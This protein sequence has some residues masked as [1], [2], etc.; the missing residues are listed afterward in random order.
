MGA[1]GFS[2]FN[3]LYY[4]AAHYTTA[5]NLGI[6][7]GSLPVFVLIGAFLAYR[8]RVTWF[9][10]IGVALT[11]AGVVLVATGGNVL[12]LASLAV[13][14]G[15]FLMVLACVCYGAYA[16]ALRQ[17][18]QASSLGLF[19][20]L[21]GAALITAIPMAATEAAMGRFQWPTAQGWVVVAL[22][23][24]FPSFLAQIFFIKGVEAIGPGRAGV[25]VNL[26]PVFGPIMAVAILSE[27]FE[28]FHGLALLFV[29]SGIWMS[30][31]GKPG[32]PNSKQGSP[33][34]D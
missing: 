29:L 20:V 25:F 10:G 12:K 18:P 6:L 30:E 23:T 15:D 34:H 8:T 16:V 21:V 22:V 31:R 2:C 32:R 24:L 11:L 27:P 17:K 33:R 1:I 19:T 14:F 13:N 28:M 9:Q 5:V 3:G 7:Q 26:V 4:V